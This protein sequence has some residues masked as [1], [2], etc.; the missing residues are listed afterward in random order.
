MRVLVQRVQEASVTVDKNLVSK[1]GKG[2]LL[3]VGIHIDDQESDLEW[4]VKKVIN[5]RV[6]EDSQGKMNCSLEQAKGE[7]LSVPQF[8]LCADMQKGNRPGFDH[9]APPEIAN[10]SWRRF[11]EALEKGGCK[12]SSGV[13]G[14]HM[15]IG[16]VNDGP[17]TIWLDSKLKKCD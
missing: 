4:M 7:L 1:I 9:S 3:F 10:E 13:F 5:L 8:T 14:A 15:D 16:L 17:V 12:V 6:F 2:Y 11:N